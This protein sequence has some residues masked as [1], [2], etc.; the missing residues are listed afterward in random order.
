M[1][2][3]LRKSAKQDTGFSPGC[4]TP[5]A[6]FTAPRWWRWALCTPSVACTSHPA[7]P[8]PPCGTAPV[9]DAVPKDLNL[10]SSPGGVRSD[11]ENLCAVGS[12]SELCLRAPSSC[13]PLGLRALPPDENSDRSVRQRLDDVPGFEPRE[14]LHGRA[15]HLQDF[16]S[17]LDCL[18]LSRGCPWGR[19]KETVCSGDGTGKGT[20]FCHWGEKTEPDAQHTFENPV[21]GERLVP[22]QGAPPSFQAEAQPCRGFL[23][24][25]RADGGLC[26]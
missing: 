22:L 6:L 23:K 20:S 17:W 9:L 15:G 18:S 8:C 13:A 2:T 5:S 16:I 1:V 24:R 7:R 19:E 14:A 10:G 4:N 26:C 11:P 12:G 21:D 25:Q 3:T